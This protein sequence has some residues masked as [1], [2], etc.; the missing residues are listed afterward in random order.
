[1]NDNKG[2][3]YRIRVATA[4]DAH[5]IASIEKATSPEP[6]SEEAL[7]NDITVNERAL[8]I[9]ATA[10]EQDDSV[11]AYA[12]A[13]MVADE[14]Q[15]NNIAVLEKYR[16]HGIAYEM[17]SVLADSG[18]EL[19]CVTMNLEVRASNEPAIRLYEKSAF[20]QVG[21]R[22][23]YYVDNNEDALLFDKDL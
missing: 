3:T 17:L 21:V 4:E 7:L 23:K 11:I 14:L 1:M 10:C 2:F 12:D 19:G 13:W 15:L 16:G 18:S 6:W 8:V 20:H 22:E 5:A 9:V